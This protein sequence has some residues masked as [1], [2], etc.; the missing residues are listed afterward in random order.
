MKNKKNSMVAH[1]TRSATELTTVAKDI[2]T[3]TLE[4]LILEMSTLFTSL[5]LSH[6]SEAKRFLDAHPDEPIVPYIV[7]L[8]LQYHTDLE[9]LAKVAASGYFDYEVQR[10]LKI[11]KQDGVASARLS[12]VFYTALD[13]AEELKISA[14]LQK[15]IKNHMARQLALDGFLIRHV[16]EHRLVLCFADDVIPA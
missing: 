13:H 2:M 3:Y 12:P 16:D 1:T 10:L 6:P 9:E 5:Y 15:K 7:N 11:A 4:G 14:K 8:A